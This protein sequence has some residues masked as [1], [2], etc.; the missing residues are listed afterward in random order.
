[1]LKIIESSI[2]QLVCAGFV[3]VC[4]ENHRNFDFQGGLCWF[5]LGLCWFVL[6]IIETTPGSKFDVLI[7]TVRFYCVQYYSIN[8]VLYA[9]IASGIPKSLAKLPDIF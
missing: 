1:M 3:L 5:V 6:K 2:F 8:F 7:H 4:A 9:F